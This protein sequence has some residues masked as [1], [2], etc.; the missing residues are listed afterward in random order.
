[1]SF[2]N[3]IFA[4]MIFVLYWFMYISACISSVRNV[5]NGMSSKQRKTNEQKYPYFHY[6]LYKKIFFFGLEGMMSKLFK[7]SVFL[8][9]ISIFLMAPLSIYL[10]IKFNR[11]L[12]YVFRGF[13]GIILIFSILARFGMSGFNKRNIG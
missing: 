4:P 12:S 11:I 2:F 13:C 8:V 10:F 6:P 7:V 1:M 5:A 9:N 3:S